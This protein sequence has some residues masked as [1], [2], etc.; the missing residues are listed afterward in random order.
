MLQTGAG[1][2]PITL[3]VFRGSF[4]SIVAQMRATLVRTA[5]SSVIYDTQDFS[6]CLLSPSGEIIGMSEEF[7]GHVFALSWG[8]P[9]LVAKFRDRIFPGDVFMMNDPYVAGTHLNDV[10]FHTPYFADGRLVM[11]VGVIAHW[12]DVGG[13]STGSLTSRASHIVEE[14]IRVPP[15]KI[16]ERG[17]KNAAVW[18]VIFSNLRFAEQQEGDAYAM[19]DTAHI[20]EV[21][22]DELCTKYGWQTVERYRDA[23]LE[24]GEQLMRSIILK[25]PDGV[26]RYENYLDNN[27]ISPAPIA[28]RLKLTIAGDCMTFD[29]SGT[30]PQSNGPINAG[31]CVAPVGAFIVV[32]SWLDP[33][34]PI[35][36][37]ALR[38]LKFILPEGSVVSARYPAGV[39]GCWEIKNAAI[40]SA[41]GCFAQFMPVDV[42]GGE[43]QGGVH[44]IVAGND[45]VTGK[46][47]MLYEFPFGGYPATGRTDGPTGCF[48]YDGGD[49]RAIQP[50]EV[51]EPAWPLLAEAARVRV[52]GESAG[53]HRSAFGVERRVKVLTEATLSVNGGRFVI[54][55]FGLRG[56]SP[57]TRNSWTV[58]REG[59]EI[60]PFGEVQGKVRS[61]PLRAGDVVIMR[62]SGGGSVGDPLTRDPSLV[63]QDVFEGYITTE[64]ARSAYGV[65]IKNR[66]AEAAATAELRSKLTALRQHFVVEADAADAYDA[67]GLRLCP[68]SPQAAARLDAHEGNLVEYLSDAGV[69]LRA[70]VKLSESGSP[71]SLALGPI[72]RGILRVDNGDRVELRLL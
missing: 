61:Y 3:E 1:I 35:N 72:G 20:A 66:K 50:A 47:F 29:F 34:T 51:V 42:L 63:E 38:P 64:R 54:P 67:N 9:H 57:G 37:G 21:R 44:C 43:I 16:V 27:G 19:I 5:Y 40:G 18:D 46:A 68:M 10:M 53:R 69:P 33:D 48:P 2:D 24:G 17:E 45:P 12:Q 65:V 4:T 70:W 41:L 56:G 25:L 71:D 62:S 6:C 39:G 55:A 14:G 30:A 11:F 23:I 7:P 31:P 52:D 59:V 49:F 28:I 15:V 13:A 58:L 36:G 26:Y 22:L 60:N 32:K 8:V